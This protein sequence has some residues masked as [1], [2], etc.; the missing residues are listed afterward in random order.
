MRE[1]DDCFATRPEAAARLWQFDLFI[2]DS[3]H[4]EQNLIFERNGACD[5]ASRRFVVATISIATGIES[6]VTSL[7]NCQLGPLFQAIL[8]ALSAKVGAEF[9]VGLWHHR[10]GM[11]LCV[12]HHS[13]PNSG[14]AH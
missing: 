14:S 5:L 4:T 13:Y 7:P 9:D 10:W 8:V 2:R 11:Y 6:F 12:T 1:E 3:R